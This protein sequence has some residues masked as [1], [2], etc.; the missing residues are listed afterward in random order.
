[1]KN[2][3]IYALT[4][5]AAMLSGMTACGA[6]DTENTDG[7]LSIV[8][9][10]FPEYDWTEQLLG[11][12]SDAAAVN[13]LLDSG[14]DLHNYQPTAQDMALIAEC[15]LFIYVGGESDEWVGDA[16]SGSVNENMQVINLLETVGDGVKEEETVEGME[17]ED[18]E[19]EEEAEPEYDEHVWLSLKNAK[20]CCKAIAE[21][22]SALDSEHAADYSANY[23][24]YAAKLDALDSDF[25]ALAER[26]A[27]KTLIF[28]D[29][30]P[31][32]Y[33][34]DDYGFDYYAAFAGCSAETEASFDTIVFLA[35]KMDEL[36]CD[37][38]YTLESS[39]GKIAQTVI[40]NTAA[41][42]QRI[43]VLDSMQSVTKEQLGEGVTYLSLTE[44]NLGV[45]RGT[46]AG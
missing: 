15:D 31:F 3:K 1:M 43:A 36:G 38:I 4:L 46:L 42:N 21:K 14:A 13:Y 11:T 7:K 32:R 24:A 37:T 44:Q 45:L 34:V 40:D 29:R 10:I 5:C 20:I 19:T 17:A 25:Q 18:E 6:S 27:Q 12:H 9:T 2:T 22:L 16:L 41:K 30:F 35:Q 23:D 28:G 33:F 26:A 39:D 8:C